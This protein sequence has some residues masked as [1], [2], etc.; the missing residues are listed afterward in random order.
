M[1]NPKCETCQHLKI[2]SGDWVDYGSTRA[3][4]PDDWEC[5]H[6]WEEGNESNDW[7][8]QQIDDLFSGKV[9]VC[10]HYLE[11]PYCPKHPTHYIDSKYGCG[12]CEEEYMKQIDDAIE[13]T[14][15]L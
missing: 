4:L 5:A 7:C 13:K 14:E 3:Q 1:D 9:K 15:R 10:P 2:L 11:L 6:E 12:A 8:N